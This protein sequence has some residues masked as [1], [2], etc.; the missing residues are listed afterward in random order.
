MTGSCSTLL[1]LVV[2]G[3]LRHH[4]GRVPCSATVCSASATVAR[5]GARDENEIGDLDGC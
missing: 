1:F 4:E 2:L 3:F 5:S